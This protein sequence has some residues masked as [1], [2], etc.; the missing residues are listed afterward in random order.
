MTRFS[1]VSGTT[2]ARVPIAATLT[3]AGSQLV[4][5][6][7]DAQRLHQFQRNA[8]AGEVLVGI[9]A[10][11]PLGIDDRERLRQLGVG[12][13]MIGDDQIETERPRPRRRLDAADAAVH[14]D[15]ECHAERVKTL[16]RGRL[17]AIAVP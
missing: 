2:S 17:Q 14:R 8:D 7:L 12:L 4:C 15:D 9:R 5:A 16:D 6:R 13:V 11:V 1:P 10:V 3:N